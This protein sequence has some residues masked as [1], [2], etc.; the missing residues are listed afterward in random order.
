VARDIN[1][2]MGTL[3]GEGPVLVD[4]PIGFGGYGPAVMR[5]LQRRGVPFVVAS[6]LDQLGSHRRFTGAN[7][8]ARLTVKV[9]DD[10]LATPPGARRVAVHNGLTAEERAE[11]QSLADR[12]Q[13]FEHD[14]G[15]RL[16]PRGKAA[17]AAFSAASG[18]PEPD[19]DAFV[20]QALDLFRAD[21][22]ELD[23][24]WRRRFERYDD[25]Q[26]RWDHE[27]VALFLGPIDH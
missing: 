24:E 16:S 12:V 26:A 7:A 10:A 2:Q 6:G 4:A 3:E 8:R 17:I 25:L 5:E 22:L 15:I 14:G 21:V 11:L 9:G 19:D 13:Q 18:L 20:A 23:D 1:R 27:T